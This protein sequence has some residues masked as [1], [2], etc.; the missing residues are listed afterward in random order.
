MR[1]PLID[2]VRGSEP[3]AVEGVPIGCHLRAVWILHHDAVDG[4]KNLRRL[5]NGEVISKGG[6]GN[7]LDLRRAVPFFHAESVLGWLGD[8]PMLEFCLGDDLE[9]GVLQVEAVGVAVLDDEALFAARIDPRVED[10]ILNVEKF[11]KTVPIPGAAARGEGID[12]F[13]FLAGGV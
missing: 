13:K 4:E 1:R 11:R 3:L 5:P 10:V 12:D 8:E 9:F 2:V 7:H 6:A